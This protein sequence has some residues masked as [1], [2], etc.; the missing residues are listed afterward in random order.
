MERTNYEQTAI[1]NEN[2]YLKYYTDKTNSEQQAQTEGELFINL[3]LRSI[4]TKISET[5]IS[6]LNDL[7]EPKSKGLTEY[8]MIFFKGDRMI[9]LGV[10]IMLI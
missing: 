1:N 9:Y 3:S 2:A 5:I 6:V 10:T 7:L 4:V 8:V